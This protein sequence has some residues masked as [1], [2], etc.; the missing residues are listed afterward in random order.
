MEAFEA[1]GLHTPLQGLGFMRSIS[2]FYEEILQDEL[3]IQIH[4]QFMMLAP[5]RSWYR[6]FYNPKTGRLSWDFVDYHIAPY[7]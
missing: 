5:R 2:R 1:H 7:R 6:D 3:D 4:N